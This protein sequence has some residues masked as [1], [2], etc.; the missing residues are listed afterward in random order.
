ML[1]QA[2]C[3]AASVTMAALSMS[4]PASNV[5]LSLRREYGR[6]L[7]RECRLDI[8]VFERKGRAALQCTDNNEPPKVL[9]AERELVPGEAT[10]L[11]TLV[12][13]SDLCSGGHT[14]LDNRPND[15]VLETLTTACPE[16]RVA[17]LVTSG[18]PTFSSNDARRRLLERM[19]ALEAE[20]QKAAPPP[21]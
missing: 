9:R 3:A 19:H 4:Q 16:A 12:G 14:G 10:G 20:L 17:I 8:N 7:Y 13:A 15:G 6:A 2:I 1:R 18:N 5:S 21:K 11:S